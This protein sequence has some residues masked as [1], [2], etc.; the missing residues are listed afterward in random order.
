MGEEMIVIPSGIMP[1][2]GFP[3]H[4]HQRVLEGDCKACHDLFPMEKGAIEKGK[5]SGKLDKKQ[6]MNKKCIGCHR[7]KL[8]KGMVAGPVKCNECHKR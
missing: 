3:H 2:P 5:T 4:L 6:V 8:Q 1:S 7:K